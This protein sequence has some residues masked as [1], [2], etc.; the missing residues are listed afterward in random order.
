MNKCSTLWKQDRELM[1]P[2][3]LRSHIMLNLD[4]SQ[5]TE[6]GIHSLNNPTT[7]HLVCHI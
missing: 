4:K 2:E 6:R 7:F 1:T 3:F 5:E